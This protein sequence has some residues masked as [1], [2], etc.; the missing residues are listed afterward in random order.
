M[1]K[2]KQYR[3]EQR[4]KEKSHPVCLPP[5][6]FFVNRSKHWIFFDVL[7]QKSS[8]YVQVYIA[9]LFTFSF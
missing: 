5:S 7:L 3:G 2:F 6:Y 8:I 4:K 1:V 9:M